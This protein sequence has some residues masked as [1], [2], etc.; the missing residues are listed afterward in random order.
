MNAAKQLRHR[1]VEDKSKQIYSDNTDKKR[2]RR[3]LLTG[4]ADL[5]V[6][7]FIS[8]LD[9]RFN[10]EIKE[11]E[12]CVRTRQ[13]DGEL[14]RSW[15]KA[16]ALDFED[17]EE[18]ENKLLKSLDLFEDLST[19]IRREKPELAPFLDQKMKLIGLL[20]EKHYFDKFKE[21]DQQVIPTQVV[22]VEQNRD[23]M[24]KYGGK[25]N[26]FPGYE[27]KK[28]LF[29]EFVLEH[30]TN[31]LKEIDRSLADEYSHLDF[32][33]LIAYIRRNFEVKYKELVIQKLRTNSP[34]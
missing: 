33:K 19:R 8:V 7:S 21:E 18:N 27:L 1:L 20:R 3:P 28:K 11:F 16:S 13:E 31:K 9:L 15:I 23:F 5:Q 30:C 34:R 12:I 24:Q 26:Q 10:T 2:V 25:I 17:D 4:K 29:R 22:V 6:A 14:N 32:S